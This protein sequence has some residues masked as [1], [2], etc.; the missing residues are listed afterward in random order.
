MDTWTIILAAAPILL[1]GLVLWL[2]MLRRWRLAVISSMLA[3][4]GSLKAYEQIVGVES[5]L[6]YVA[7]VFGFLGILL[8]IREALVSR[9]VEHESPRRV[10]H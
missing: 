3:V 1:F 9:R 4:A 10:R 8:L 6:Y 2:L 7:H 5:N